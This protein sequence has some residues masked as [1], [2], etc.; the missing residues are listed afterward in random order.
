MTTITSGCPADRQAPGDQDRSIIELATDNRNPCISSSSGH[1]PDIAH[2]G[3]EITKMGRDGLQ[4]T[5]LNIELVVR[6]ETLLTQLAHTNIG[7]HKATERFNFS[8]SVIQ[9]DR[10]N[11]LSD[12]AANRPVPVRGH[13]SSNCHVGNRCVKHR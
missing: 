7:S 3:M 13:D 1:A 10:Y 9:M 2:S 4:Q 6:L 11:A 12:G 5:R 8:D